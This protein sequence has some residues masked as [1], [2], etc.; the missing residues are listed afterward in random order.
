MRTLLFLA[1]V[2]LA[3]VGVSCAQELDYYTPEPSPVTPGD[4]DD[5]P[6]A[7]VPII[8]EGPHRPGVD[9]GPLGPV[10]ARDAMVRDATSPEAGARDAG[11]D[12]DAR[13]PIDARAD[14]DAFTPDAFVDA[15]DAQAPPWILPHGERRGPV[16][17]ATMCPGPAPVPPTPSTC[18]AWPWHTPL[19][20]RTP[21]ECAALHESSYCLSVFIGGTAVFTGL[22]T[23]SLCLAEFFEQ[24]PLS[25]DNG[26]LAQLGPDLFTTNLGVLVKHSLVD[27]SFDVSPREAS[28]VM[29]MGEQLVIVTPDGRLLAYPSWSDL[30]LDQNARTLGV[31]SPA[32]GAV[33]G[34]NRTTVAAAWQTGRIDLFTPGVSA[35]VLQVRDFQLDDPIMG[36]DLSED[37]TQIQLLTSQGI[38]II[39]AMTGSTV[40]RLAT[41]GS[42]AGLSCAP[43]LR[44]G[45]S[46]AP[47]PS[48]P[49]PGFYY[50]PDRAADAI[51]ASSDCMGPY[52]GPR[53]YGRTNGPE[54]LVLATY[55]NDNPNIVT[56]E[57]TTP[58]TLVLTTM[59]GGQWTVRVAPNAMLERILVNGGP[60]V[61]LSVESTRAIPI[62]YHLDNSDVGSLG[63]AP[64]SWPERDQTMLQARLEEYTGTALTEL[65][66]CHFGNTFSVR[67]VPPLCV[68]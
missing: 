34:A 5:V 57:R 49:R 32:L 21:T 44:P 51:L 42:L 9:A 68:P 19:C 59:M 38:W 35:R 55:F 56:D 26:A 65:L 18:R 15:S 37:G 31:V 67:D 6:D 60:G 11:P 30:N 61:T 10:G 66:G 39:D 41:A 53:Y 29:V 64:G 47:L 28:S 40:R 7:S 17:L 62:E 33:F 43:G 24:Y 1:L 12:A 46:V 58:H 13:A 45:E 23:G 48:E 14:A 54:L 36:V 52:N 22:D 27:G 2:S 4:D 16:S 50:E 20:Y 3:L 63:S 25:A 8:Q